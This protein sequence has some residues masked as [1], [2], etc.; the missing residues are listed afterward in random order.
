VKLRKTLPMK[1][2]PPSGLMQLSRSLDVNKI[3]TLSS[4]P[5]SL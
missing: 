2:A 4:L 5:M 1:F 3:T